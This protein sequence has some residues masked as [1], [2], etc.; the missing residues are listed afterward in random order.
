MDVTHDLP[1][2]NRP[3]RA[4]LVVA[5][6]H[7]HTLKL[8]LHFTARPRK[9]ARDR[10]GTSP[11]ELLDAFSLPIETVTA[12]LHFS[13]L[14]Q[15]SPSASLQKEAWQQVYPEQTAVRA[16]KAPAPP[17]AA[18]ATTIVTSHSNNGTTGESKIPHTRG[19]ATN[20]P[21][22]ANSRSLLCEY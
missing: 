3:S 17:L 15:Q 21:C 12:P 16:G 9:A 6:Q 19:L 10:D 11:E 8:L 13:F 18:G 5:D 22:S 7:A 20:V 14:Q 1:S 4:A 2:S